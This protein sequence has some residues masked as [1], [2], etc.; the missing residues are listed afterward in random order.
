MFEQ[1]I[2]GAQSFEDEK[3]ESKLLLILDDIEASKKQID[4]L[5]KERKKLSKD[6]KDLN[7]VLDE[8]KV[9]KN[10]L[11]TVP[12]PLASSENAQD[13]EKKFFPFYNSLENRETELEARLEGNRQLTAD[14]N[15]QFNYLQQQNKNLKAELKRIED[16]A[17]KEEDDFSVS[18]NDL[19]DLNIKLDN[20]TKENEFLL[21][22]C[23]ELKSELEERDSH[24]KDSVMVQFEELTAQYKEDQQIL[25]ELKKSSKALQSEINKFDK[26]SQA[27][28]DSEKEKSAKEQAINHWKADRSVLK[29]KLKNLKTQLFSIQKNIEESQKRDVELEDKYSKL[30]GE[31]HESGQCELARKCLLASINQAN[32]EKEAVLS[33][34]DFDYETDYTTQLSKETECIDKSLKIFHQYRDSQLESLNQELTQCSQYGFL[35]LLKEEL[36]ELQKQ[37]LNL[38]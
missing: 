18:N 20:S 33:S 34:K 11:S 30:L 16:E 25:A 13:P 23:E 10:L 27:N 3:D 19:I 28:Y 14:L 4:S 29:D 35:T 12:K 9:Q 32:E 1:Q 36:E 22:K 37:L 31:E 6:L 21:Q 24:L 7:F 38:Q 2:I 8:L 17:A 15:H 5:E 26:L